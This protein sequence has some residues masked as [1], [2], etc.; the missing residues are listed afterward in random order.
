MISTGEYPCYYWDS[1]LTD[2]ED[3][4]KHKYDC[5]VPDKLQD[6]CD[7]CGGKFEYRIQNIH[8]LTG[9]FCQAGF[10]RIEE[11][12]CHMRMEHRNYLPG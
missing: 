7:Q 12:Q 10:E 1:V 6:K 8:S 5:P 4:T 11:L 3:L 2:S 9:D